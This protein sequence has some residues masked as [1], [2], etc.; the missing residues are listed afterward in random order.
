MKVVSQLADILIARDMSNRELARQADIG[1]NAVGNLSKAHF[2]AS[3][4]INLK[5]LAKICQTLN[6]VPGDLLKLESG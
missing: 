5:T 6:I 2:S 4:I 3:P 1:A